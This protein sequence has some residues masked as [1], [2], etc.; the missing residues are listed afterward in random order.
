VSSGRVVSEWEHALLKTV[1]QDG[2]TCIENDSM[3]VPIELLLWFSVS[4]D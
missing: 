3:F 4:S 1:S 2:L